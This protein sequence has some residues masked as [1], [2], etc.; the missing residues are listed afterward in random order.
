MCV[1][2]MV[3]LSGGFSDPDTVELEKTANVELSG[4]EK[5]DYELS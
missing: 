2:C 4:V 3:L 1:I 5:N